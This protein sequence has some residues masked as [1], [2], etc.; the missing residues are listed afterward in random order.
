MARRRA[1]WILPTLGRHLYEWLPWEHFESTDATR[2][3]L[4]GFA[5]GRASDTRR[6]YGLW[7]DDVLVGGTLFP[8]INAGAGT[9]ELGVFLAKDARGQGIVTR[10]VEA[11]IDWAFGVRGLRR[12]EWRC[13]PATSRAARFRDGSDSPTRA[14]CG[15]CSGCVRT[16]TTSRSGRCSATSGAPESDPPVEPAAGPAPHTL[17]QMASL[18]ATSHPRDHADLCRRC[19]EPPSEPTIGCQSRLVVNRVVP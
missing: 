10:T 15:R 1:G 5:D 3:F 16:S 18:P 12:L 13:A 6:I 9:A 17:I 14:P 7:L 2:K 8:S 19:S 4:K 11:M